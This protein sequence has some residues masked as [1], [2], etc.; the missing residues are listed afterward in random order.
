MAAPL[1]GGRGVLPGGAISL[2]YPQPGAQQLLEKGP[3][4]CRHPSVPATPEKLGTREARTP[5][6][7][8]MQTVEGAA[9][10]AMSRARPPPLHL[11]YQRVPQ[12]WGGWGMAESA[13]RNPSG[14]H[15]GSASTPSPRPPP[16]CLQTQI[17]TQ[18]L[19]SAHITPSKPSAWGGRGPFHSHQRESSGRREPVG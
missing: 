18:H 1:A 15:L 5:H 4:Y 2:R 12:G 17:F 8:L 7:G 11:Q 14:T 10:G 16:R 13:T 19:S 9:R 3:A 6:P